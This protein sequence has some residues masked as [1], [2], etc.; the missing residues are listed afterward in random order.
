LGLDGFNKV[1]MKRIF[2]V[3][4]LRECPV[5]PNREMEGRLEGKHTIIEYDTELSKRLKN[6][7][8]N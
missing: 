5:I 8:L 3:T 7:K 2:Q 6:T 1:E 4:G